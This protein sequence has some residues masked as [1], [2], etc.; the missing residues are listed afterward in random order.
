MDPLITAVTVHSCGRLVSKTGFRLKPIGALRLFRHVRTA[1]AWA[2]LEGDELATKAAR[3]K[4]DVR[5][6]AIRHVRFSQERRLHV[7][8]LKPHRTR[9]GDRGFA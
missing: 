2:C 1:R 7:S 5:L 3:V 4:N 8:R 6:R 9:K